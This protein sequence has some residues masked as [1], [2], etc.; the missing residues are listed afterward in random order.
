M[1]EQ[2]VV[3][4]IAHSFFILDHCLPGSRQCSFSQGF[5]QNKSGHYLTLLQPVSLP[6]QLRIGHPLHSQPRQSHPP[7][8][9]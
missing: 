7:M 4:Q 5:E 3:F 8:P 1:P 2:P 9:A 6:R